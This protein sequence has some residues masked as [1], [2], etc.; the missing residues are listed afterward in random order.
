[1]TRIKSYYICKGVNCTCNT[2][3]KIVRHSAPKLHDPLFN[4]DLLLSS[5]EV[6]R[7]ADCTL[8]A[9]KIEICET[10]NSVEKLASKVSIPKIKLLLRIL[11]KPKARV[12]LT[13]PD[14]IKLTLQDQ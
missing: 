12:S 1:M 2:N 11:A 4:E 10:C 5:Y 7:H 8:L 13:S 6:Y 3:I 9:N 14:R